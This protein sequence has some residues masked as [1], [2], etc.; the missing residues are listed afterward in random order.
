MIL[1]TAANSS[2]APVAP[3]RLL[4]ITPWLQLAGGLLAFLLISLFHALSSELGHRISV[5]ESPAFAWARVHIAWLLAGCLTYLAIVWSVQVLALVRSGCPPPRGMRTLAGMELVAV[6]VLA[7]AFLRRWDGALV[8]GHTLLQLSLV[9]QALVIL[10]RFGPSGAYGSRLSAAMREGGHGLFLALVFLLAAVP[11]YL[12]PSWHRLREHVY[13][14]S[15]WDLFWSRMLPMLLSG[16]TGLWL[17]SAVLV[18]LAVSRR[19]RTRPEGGLK[20]SEPV[21]LLPFLSMAALVGAVGVVPLFQSTE[22]ELGALRLRGVVPP[23]VILLCGGGGALYWMTFQRLSVHAPARRGEPVI[24]RVAL[25]MGGMLILPVTWLLTRPNAGRRS[26]HWLLVLSLLAS[27]GLEFTVLYGGLFDPW[28]TVFSVLKGTILKSCAV[29]VAGILTLVIWPRV[30]GGKRRPEG[31][32]FW[33]LMVTACLAGFLPF[34]ALERLPDTKVAILQFNELSMVDATYA[35]LAATGLGLK[36]WIRLGQNPAP[37]DRSD[38]WPQPWTLRR[39]GPSLLPRDFNLLVIVVDS[40]RGDAFRSAGYHR[41]LT[42]FLDQWARQE[43]VSFRRAYSQGGGTFAAYPFL[44]GGRSRFSL[45][46]PEVY[47]ENLYFKLAQAE[48]IRHVMLVREFGPRE[49]F[50]PDFA[51]IELAGPG[52]PADGRSTPAG[53]VFQWARQAIGALPKGERFLAF[54]HLMDVHNRLWKKA[55]SV[56][57]GETPRDLYDN[58]VA[59]LDKTLE[60][61]VAWLKAKGIYERTIILFTADHGEQFWEHGASLHGHTLYEEEIRIP[62]IL[63]THG[64]RGRVEDV[65]VVAADV[66]PTLA[67]LA[68]YSVHP[69][70][71][72]SHMGISLVPLLLGKERERYLKRDVVGRASFKRRY[73]FYRNWEWKLVYSADFDLLQLFNTV[74]DPQERR[75]LL[76]E[77]RGLATELEHKLLAYLDRVE[78]KSYRPQLS[79]AQEWGQPFA[80][81]QPVAGSAGR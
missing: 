69:P 31:K 10:S 52:A 81:G 48:G 13:L 36:D 14:E 49:I 30:G 53:T 34:V 11:G 74:R 33:S 37:T 77:E 12:D 21:S 43:A 71:Q 56:D 58:N 26:W 73:F 64:L 9:G 47:R 42:P 29:V 7:L 63:V 3:R 19:L 78:G 6:G 1:F 72:D 5:G 15:G 55:E 62:L 57:F 70:Y 67:E 45:Y 22:W 25:A 50:P 44:V 28:Y 24:G 68:G 38:P 23:L 75:N 2:P 20:A 46:G 32:T 39:T 40:L 79:R 54:L 18:G 61:F 76:R 59:Y 41:D 8:W 65:P 27:L 35:R 4:R 16:V 17:G 80:G 66:A 60:S 51:V